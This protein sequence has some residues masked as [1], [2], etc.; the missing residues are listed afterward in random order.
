MF[1]GNITE[2]EREYLNQLYAADLSMSEGERDALIRNLYDSAVKRQQANQSAFESLFGK[3][4]QTPQEG[5]ELD[6]YVFLG[7]DPADPKNWRTK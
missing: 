5:Q 2:G 4:M 7:G 1:G 6:G 3:Q